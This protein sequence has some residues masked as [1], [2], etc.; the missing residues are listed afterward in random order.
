MVKVYPLE[1]LRLK[2][3]VLILQALSTSQQQVML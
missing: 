2:Y 3:S 1:D